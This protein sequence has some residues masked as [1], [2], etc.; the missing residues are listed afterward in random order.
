MR[1]VHKRRVHYVTFDENTGNIM[2]KGSCQLRTVSEQIA[3][4]ALDDGE[5]FMI[6]PM[7][8]NET[9][10]MIDLTDPLDPQ[11]VR[12]LPPTD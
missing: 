3:S 8:T 9:D 4:V 12:R 5:D 2:S 1:T 6:V 11:V 7:G 10:H